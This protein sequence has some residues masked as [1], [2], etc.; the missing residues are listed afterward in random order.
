MLIQETVCP[1]SITAS[2]LRRVYKHYF[3]VD[4]S[5]GL[6]VFRIHDGV[7]VR[8]VLRQHGPSA[9]NCHDGGCEMSGAVP[10]ARHSARS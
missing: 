4:C 2:Q 8:D 9:G 7:V 10:S 6:L 1:D 5:T 3:G